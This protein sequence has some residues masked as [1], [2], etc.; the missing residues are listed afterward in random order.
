MKVILLQDVPK[1][2]QRGDIVE[3]NDGY[4]QNL[5]LPR[6]LAVYATAESIARM[7]SKRDRIAK[8]KSDIQKQLERSIHDLKGKEVVINASASESGHLF[9]A[10]HESDIVAAIK[11]VHDV[12]L[13]EENIKIAKPIK[14]IGLHEISIEGGG[15]GVPFMVHVADKG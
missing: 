9:A 1:T 10:I 6:G 4:A 15:V 13:S 2:G 11:K 14:E 8:K 5:L 12:Q 3:V 7:A